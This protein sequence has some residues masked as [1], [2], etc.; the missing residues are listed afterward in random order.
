MSLYLVYSP[1]TNGEIVLAALEVVRRTFN[2]FAEL[3]DRG[4]VQE[5]LRQETSLLQF[6]RNERN[7]GCSLNSELRGKIS[8]SLKRFEKIFGAPWQDKDERLN[9]VMLF[10]TLESIIRAKVEAPQYS[11]SQD[12]FG[13]Q[14]FLLSRERLLV[15]ELLAGNINNQDLISR[16]NSEL[17]HE[18]PLSPRKTYLNTFGAC[19]NFQIALAT[20]N[21]RDSLSA[22]R[23]AIR[24]FLIFLPTMFLWWRK[25]IVEFLLDNGIKEE[26]IRARESDFAIE[27]LLEEFDRQSAVIDAVGK[28]NADTDNVLADLLVFDWLNSPC[29]Q[30][31][32]SQISIGLARRDSVWWEPFRKNK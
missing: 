27:L 20:A 7:H 32:E 5:Q 3:K 14:P 23:L 10:W 30:A 2:Y 13:G 18:K 21:L 9:R 11:S 8:E 31:V 26:F 4:D 22:T 6:R 12:L 15:G 29:E 25:A 16:I 24:S 1:I 17:G 28:F 19:R